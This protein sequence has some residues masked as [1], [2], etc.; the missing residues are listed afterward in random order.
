MTRRHGVLQVVA[1]LL[2]ALLVWAGGAV[3]NGQA[4]PEAVGTSYLMASRAMPGGAPIST[5]RFTL[6]FVDA[7]VSD[8]F[9]ALSTQSG[10]NVATSGSVSGKVTLRLRNVTLE[11]ALNIVTKLNGFE[12][13]W[14]E[15]AYV[16]GTPEEVRNMKVADLRTS[17]VM[18]QHVQP[19][20]AQTVISK[21]TPD[22][23]VSVQK[24]V[25]SI[26][27]LG[28]EASLAKAERVIAEI[29]RP[30]LPSRP[31]ANVLLVRYLRADSLANMIT[32]SVPD[33][34][35]QPGPQDN[36]LVVTCNDQQ[37]ETVQSVATACD[38]KPTEA[39]ATQAI[40]YVKY[41][42]PTE[43]KTTLF[44]L[45]PEL[46][47]T[48]SARSY[49]PVVSKLEGA[50]G[51][52]GLSAIQYGGKASGGGG[53]GGGASSGGGS[54]VQLEAAPITALILSGAP[55]TVEKGLKMLEQL[56]KAPKQVHIAATVTEI[57]RD[58]LLRLGIDWSGLGPGAA[59]V[60]GEP[61]ER[62][63]TVD[64]VTGVQTLGKPDAS[65]MRPLQFGTIMRTPIQWS[66]TL[67]ALEESGRARI[68]SNPSV[69]TL[70]GRQTALHT[71][72]TLL[73]NVVVGRDINGTIVSTAELKVGV[74]L[75][76][77]PRVNE[78]GEITLTMMPS[79]SKIVGFNQGLPIVAERAVV[80]TVRVKSGETAV[81]AGLITDED[82]VD[83]SKVPFLGNLPVL[84]EA[85]K[86]RRRNPTHTEILIFVTPTI[87]GC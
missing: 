74:N 80:T 26:L 7:D 42:S 16:V 78:N 69:T 72:D 34:T 33:C 6:E 76:V 56:D 63:V 44:D 53:G 67:H 22:V 50:A 17:V 48:L 4:K 27:L 45:M 10:V 37:W 30:S 81:I 52:E 13:A 68:L 31:K 55:W 2:L 43:L 40:Y 35:I 51:T 20:Y 84:G 38:V 62:D 3:A 21:V 18:L 5:A 75:T 25:Q 9:Q 59:F 36:S 28:P 87:I 86:F 1:A 66:A 70:D 8:V 83:V 60:M 79:V 19:D 65:L 47:V 73:Y 46:K 49:T 24:G 12:Y 41:T 14:V 82:R 23:T 39:Q 71:G 85:F 64:P 58:D 11:Q 32:T 15:A 77:N 57:N 61:L 29:D 54:G